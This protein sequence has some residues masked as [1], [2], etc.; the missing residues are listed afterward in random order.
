MKELSGIPASKGIVI[1]KAML[2]LEDALPEIP[3]Y[4][5]KE[6]QAN[7][8]WQR[9]LSAVAAITEKIRQKLKENP[10][11]DSKE[12]RDILEAQLLMFEDIDFHENVKCGMES[13]LQNIESIV[14]D[15]SQE[16]I[17]KLAALPGAEFRARIADV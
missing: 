2:Y 8:E 13:R 7:E 6:T 9:F 16:L 17:Q 11:K 15:V 10:V 4:N 14:W 1:G 12:R 5:I 3:R